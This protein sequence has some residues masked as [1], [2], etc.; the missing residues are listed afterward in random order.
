MKK[1]QITR[2]QFLKGALAGTAG[3]AA[4]SI[5]GPAA[6]AEG[7]QIVDPAIGNEVHV[8]SDTPY[9]MSG[10]QT[11]FVPDKVLSSGYTMPVIGIGT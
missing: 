8:I 4:M 11:Y 3:L 9:V 7:S 5:L 1:E 2:R 10:D 6:F